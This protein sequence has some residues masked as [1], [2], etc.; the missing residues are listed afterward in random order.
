[1]ELNRDGRSKSNQKIKR[2]FLFDCSQEILEMIAS[3]WLH[4]NV[5]NLI[6]TLLISIQVEYVFENMHMH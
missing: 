2:K 6:T 5:F 4:Q 1:M 3:K